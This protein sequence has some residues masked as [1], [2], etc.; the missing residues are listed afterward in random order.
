[1]QS[2]CASNYPTPSLTWKKS[3]APTAR[4]TPMASP[5][6]KRMRTSVSRVRVILGSCPVP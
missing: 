5:S 3:R 1:M 2:T 6:P 4:M